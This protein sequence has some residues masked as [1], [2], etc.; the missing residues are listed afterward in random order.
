VHTVC[1]NCGEVRPEPKSFKYVS[2]ANWESDPF[3]SRVCAEESYGTV[4]ASTG[5][6]GIDYGA[7]ARK[8]TA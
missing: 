1:A 5:G 4:P 8:A 7:T 3:C 6:Y 2:R